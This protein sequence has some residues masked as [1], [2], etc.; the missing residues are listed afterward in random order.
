[1]CCSIFEIGSLEYEDK[2]Y[3]GLILNN[4]NMKP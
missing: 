1:M 4:P 2:D 3:S